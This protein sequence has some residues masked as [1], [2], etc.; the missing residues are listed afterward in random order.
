MQG[1]FAVFSL[2]ILEFEVPDAWSVHTRPGKRLHNELEK[3]P[4]FMENVTINGDFP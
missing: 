4:F 1:A 3:S 2:Q